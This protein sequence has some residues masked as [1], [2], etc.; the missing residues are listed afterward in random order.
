MEAL[1]IKE[2]E[3]TPKIILD[4]DHN[5][6]E[7]TGNSLPENILGFYAP[8]FNWIEEYVKQPNQITK[9]VVKLNYFNSSS[10]KIILDLIITLSS[11]VLRGY[12]VEVEWFY[13]DMDEDNLQTGK[14][15]E[16]FAKIPFKFI[17]YQDDGTA[18]R[19]IVE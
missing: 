14:E 2:E 19:F 11:L 16:G 17:P 10:S 1:N 13:M 15:F 8:V 18:N 12:K 5:I 7:I 4:K 3:G 9:F 6:F